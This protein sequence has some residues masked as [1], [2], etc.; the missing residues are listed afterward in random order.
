MGPRNPLLAEIL[1]EV[2]HRFQTRGGLFVKTRRKMQINF[3]TL[4]AGNS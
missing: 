2:R 4:V 1:I 3:A